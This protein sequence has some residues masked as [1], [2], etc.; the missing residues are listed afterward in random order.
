M[1][2]N[3]LLLIVLVGLTAVRLLWLCDFKTME[4][5]DG[6]GNKPS[7]LAT[8]SKHLSNYT[9]SVQNFIT[10]QVRKVFPSPH[11]E[12]LLGLTIGLNDLKKVSRFNDVLLVTGT[13]H[14][15]VVSGYNINLVFNL[16]ISI[17][18]SKYK[19][20]NLIT[21]QVLTFIYAVICGLGA[22]VIRA[23]I[24]GSIVSWGAYYGR[25]FEAL[26]ILFIS[27]LFMVMV[28]PSFLFSLSFKLSFL[29]T[30]SL[31]MFSG[32][33]VDRIGVLDD[34]KTTIAAQILV[35]PLIS[36][37]FGRISLISPIVNWLILW[38][39]P[40]ATVLGFIFILL[41]AVWSYL[42]Y[43]GSFVLYLPLD[44]FVKIV[45][46]FGNLPFASINFKIS[47]SFLLAY[48]FILFAGYFSYSIV[49]SK[50][51]NV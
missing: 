30:L 47:L 44:F 41:S 6:G 48:Y 14:V 37:R 25:K 2:K 51:E 38:T 29:A 24:M 22:P 26:R 15:V 39:I 18:G 23:W 7:G 46:F 43:L 9:V 21:A 20:K 35:W 31:M 17:L 27:A 28:V 42:G 32:I 13:V 10:S 12:L 5:R 34:F 19:L 16:I 45:Y 33:I 8:S 36:Y 1:I 49:S 40:L 11:S 50:N 4:C 3:N